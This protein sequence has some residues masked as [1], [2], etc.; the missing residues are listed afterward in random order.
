MAK[1]DIKTGIPQ[2]R[3]RLGAFTLVILGEIESD[4]PVQY[5]YILA[6]V[7]E[8]D[9]E[10]GMYITVERVRGGEAAY[11]LRVLMRDGEEV[12]GSSDDY[13]DLDSFVEEAV[14]VVKAVLNLADEQLRPL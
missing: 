8:G 1:P 13:G 4:D 2:R 6:A 3:Y 10:P 12:V 7:H 5:K 11:Q 9:S 14:R